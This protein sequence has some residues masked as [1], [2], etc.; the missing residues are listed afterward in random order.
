M[1]ASPDLDALAD[2]LLALHDAGGLVIPFSDRFAG[3][4]A[5]AGYRAAAWLH[6]ARLARGWTPL[7]RKIGF[8]NRTIW[9]RYG[10]YEPMASIA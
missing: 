10:V 7:G 9:P 8:T 5:E 1:A 3:L 4:T 6:A 2:E